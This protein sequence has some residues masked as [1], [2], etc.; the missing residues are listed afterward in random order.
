E[1]YQ[2]ASASFLLPRG[3]GL[4]WI[5]HLRRYKSPA[6]EDL[7]ALFGS[8][9]SLGLYTDEKTIPVGDWGDSNTK[10]AWGRCSHCAL[11]FISPNTGGSGKFFVSN[12]TCPGCLKASDIHSFVAK[13]RIRNI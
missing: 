2:Q 4:V 11:L 6:R 3:V 10:S 7:L 12:V 1:P 8:H 9:T 5:P 13:T